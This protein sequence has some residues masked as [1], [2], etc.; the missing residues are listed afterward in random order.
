MTTKKEAVANAIAAV[1]E[2]EVYLRNNSP[3]L[4]YSWSVIADTWAN[5]ASAIPSAINQF[6]RRPDGLYEHRGPEDDG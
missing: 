3:E 5:I 2:A 4:A 1:T 6:R